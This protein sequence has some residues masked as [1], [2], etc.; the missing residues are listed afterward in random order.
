MK[1]EKTY[2]IEHREFNEIIL[3]YLTK[4]FEKFENVN[5]ISHHVIQDPLRDDHSLM[6]EKI[7]IAT[8]VEVKDE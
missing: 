3:D 4:Y 2:I 8:E 6:L 1:I 7:V 5:S